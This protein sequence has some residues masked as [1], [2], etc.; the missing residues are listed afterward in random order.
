[1]K[2]LIATDGSEFSRKALEKCCQIIADPQ[3][4]EI[5]IVSVAEQAMPIPAEPYVVSADYVYTL[6]SLA[7]KQAESCVEKSVKTLKNCIPD[8]EINLTTK[9]LSGSPAQSIVAEA[10]EWKADLIVVGSHGYGFWERMM[11]GSVSQSVIQHAP[12]SV[13]VVRNSK[14]AMNSDENR[15]AT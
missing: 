2:I 10:E 3:K 8:G 4:A 13:L 9:T 15:D 11:L 7:R 5:R 12:C 14:K 1:M 6:D